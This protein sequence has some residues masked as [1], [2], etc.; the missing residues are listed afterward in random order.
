MKESISIGQ[1][2]DDQPESVSGGSEDDFKGGPPQFLDSLLHR[3]IMVRMKDGRPIKGVLE[4]YN[5]YELLI[6]L[7]QSKRLIIFKGAISS[8]E[9]E[10]RPEKRAG[11]R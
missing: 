6:D 7:G 11:R 2:V 1:N 10:E 5:N 4:A 9:A 8:I 3:P